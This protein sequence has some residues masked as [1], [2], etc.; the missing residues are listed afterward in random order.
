MI[1][2]LS[3]CKMKFELIVAEPAP[4]A[5]FQFCSEMAL[6]VLFLSSINSLL[7]KP[8]TGV[9]SAI[10]SVM[11]MSN[12]LADCAALPTGY[13]HTRHAGNSRCL[14]GSTRKIICVGVQNPVLNSEKPDCKAE[15]PPKIKSGFSLLI[16]KGFNR[17]KIA[18]RF[19][20]KRRK[21]KSLHTSPKTYSTVS[22]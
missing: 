18:G 5:S 6:V 2:K 21:F 14:N 20:N 13:R 22:A 17:E 12:R 3:G 4:S 19:L 1:T 8:T 9:G 10:S 11:I 7:G 16:K 15:S